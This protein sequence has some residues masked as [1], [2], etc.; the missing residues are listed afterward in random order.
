MTIASGV[1]KRVRYKIESAWG[2]LA[3]ASGAQSLRRVSSDL[4]LR[5]DTFQSN[6]IRTDYQ[7]ADMR[8]GIRRVS[9]S[10]NG[11]LSPGTYQ[12]FI[13]A[14]VRQA[15]EADAAVGVITN[16]T[17]QATAPQFARA[18]GSWITDGLKLYDVIRWTG[19]AGGSAPNNNSRNFLITGLT[20]LNMTGVFLDGSA[21]VADASGDS[22]SCSLVG[23]KAWVPSTGHTDSSFTI[24]HWF[25]D[26]AQ[27][28]QFAGCKLNQLDIDMPP[29]G[30]ATISMQFMGKDA[31]YGTSEY[32]TS[33]TAETTTP[34]AV[35]VS[36][37][38]YANG[39]AVALLTGLKV[40]IKGNMQEA[41]PVVGSNT[42]ADI[43]E[44]RVTV[45]GEM[46]VLFQDATFRDYF[47]DETEVSLQA[48]LTT[49]SSATADFVSIVLPR[50]K[51]MGAAK[52]DGEKSLV[53]TLPFQGLKYVGGA[54]N[55]NS[56]TVI[57]QDSQAS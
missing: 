7:T 49:G 32:F 8:H 33:P 29:T 45:D 47:D 10:I 35:S 34:L 52:D 37:K 53:Q 41:P 16:V 25:E 51:V 38:L 28:E 1:A 42:V 50:I 56:T 40:S 15:F 3:G 36:G 5:K 57:I 11:E 12:A 22:V 21:V 14:A 30:I 13:A 18:S 43:A 24:E 6:E 54:S 2:T 55:I 46:S 9:G 4:D 31:T 48:I 17:A 20:A 26:I 23:K 19:F 44:G 27:S 39:S